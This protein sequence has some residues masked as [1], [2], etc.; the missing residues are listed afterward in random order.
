MDNKDD[1]QAKLD[2]MKK[3][4]KNCSDRELDMMGMETGMMLTIL[5]SQHGEKHENTVACA[6][7]LDILREEYSRRHKEDTVKSQAEKTVKPKEILVIP[8]TFNELMSL[9]DGSVGEPEMS[10]I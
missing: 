2:G 7:L 10:K 8:K 1:L 9:G 5:K 4:I 3:E 6:C